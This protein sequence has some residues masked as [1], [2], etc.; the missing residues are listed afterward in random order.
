MNARINHL[1]L[2]VVLGS[3]MG[4]L[5]AVADAQSPIPIKNICHVKGQ[6]ENSLRAFGIVTG[7]RGT[8]DGGDFAAT[9]RSLSRIMELAGHPA[10]GGL[11]ELKNTKNVALVDIQVTIPAEGARQGSKLDCVVN[12][13]G[14]A[15][16]LD[17][18]HL[19]LTFLVGP[20]PNNPRVYATAE[21]RIRLDDPEFPTTG[22]ISQG[23]QLQEDFFNEFVDKTNNTITLV[24]DDAHATW[25]IADD[26][27]R[28]INVQVSEQTHGSL[29]D[30][31][32]A[33]DQ[34]NIVVKIPS[35]YH[36]NPVK[37]INTIF[38]LT[39][40]QVAEPGARVTINEST[41]VVTVSGDVVIGP[42]V[43]TH[44]NIVVD[45]GGSGLGGRFVPVDPAETSQATLEGLLKALNAI[46]VQDTDIIDII[47]SLKRNG[48]I[49]ARVDFE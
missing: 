43:V 9:I 18:G 20:D 19:F 14:T 21:G 25:A 46:H 34:K 15:K 44:N 38:G 27:A 49:H 26:V 41:G 33:I 10:L 36:L 8:G 2:L 28:Q 30:W 29:D 17:G 22:K 6:E 37:Y 31:A 3:A 16:S 35:Q 4:L 48:R 24:I 13:V 7:L 42:A 47:K 1:L 12:S 23:A 5:A 45:T 32:T 39:E 11:D 40:L